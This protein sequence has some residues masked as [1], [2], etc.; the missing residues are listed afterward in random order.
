[1]PAY[2]CISSL[3][4]VSKVSTLKLR[5]IS[6]FKNGERLYEHNRLHLSTSGCKYPKSCIRSARRFLKNLCPWVCLVEGT[7]H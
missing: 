1:M 2:I 5:Y 3:E 6:I 4:N 7:G